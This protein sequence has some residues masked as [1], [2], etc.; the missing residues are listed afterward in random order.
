MFKGRTALLSII[1]ASALIVCSTDVLYANEKSSK[2]VVSHNSFCLQSTK[3]ILNS[4]HWSLKDKNDLQNWLLRVQEL[5][6]NSANFKQLQEDYAGDFKLNKQTFAFCIDASGMPVGFH[7]L[8][9][10]SFTLLDEKISAIVEA[11]GPYPAAPNSLPWLE[12]GMRVELTLARE[13]KISIAPDW[14]NKR[15]ASLSNSNL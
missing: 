13:F 10:E 2:G 7:V 3:A 1:G 9:R 15:L 5:I 12:G 4:T 8:N 14:P 11:A 6:V